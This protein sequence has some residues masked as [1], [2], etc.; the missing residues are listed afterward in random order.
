M[1]I[2]MFYAYLAVPVG[3]MLMGIRFIEATV[4]RYRDLQNREGEK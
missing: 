2:P 4:Y 1:E 3:C